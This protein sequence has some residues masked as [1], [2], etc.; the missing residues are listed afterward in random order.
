[1]TKILT[2]DEMREVI[3]TFDEVAADRFADELKTIGERMAAAI[4][5]KFDLTT[6]AR[7]VTVEEAELGGTA[8]PFYLTR[9]GQTVD[10]EAFDYFDQGEELTTWTGFVASVGGLA[11][12]Q[13]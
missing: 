3:A 8:A 2:L 5:E 12:G 11:N 7:G 10:S 6:G 1:M 4:C 13:I 9:E